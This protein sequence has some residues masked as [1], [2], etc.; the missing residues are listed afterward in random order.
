MANIPE[1]LCEILASE[2]VGDPSIEV[3]ISLEESELLASIARFRP[4]VVIAGCSD[5]LASYGED[6]PE[7]YLLGPGASWIRHVEL[8]PVSED[9]SDASLRE[10]VALIKASEGRPNAGRLT[11]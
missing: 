3:L 10:L 1:M 9:M 6:P 2:L 4:N 11:L 7:L 5:A 8:R